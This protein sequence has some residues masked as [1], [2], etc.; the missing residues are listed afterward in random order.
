MEGTIV[1]QSYYKNILGIAFHTFKTLKIAYIIETII[2]LIGL[3]SNNFFSR[4]TMG[5]DLVPTVAT[6]LTANFIAH[7]IVFSL[8][9]SKDHG[10]LLFLTPIKGIEFLAGHF[11]ELLLVDSFIVVA[12]AVVGSIN[13]H[14]LAS[15]LITA[16]L[17]ILVGLLSAH[18]IITGTIAIVGSYIRSTGLCILGVI[19]CCGFGES[20][21]SWI[22]NA[23]ISFMP[24]FYLSIGRLGLI[25]IDIFSVILD[26]L[27]LIGLQIAAAYMI[28]KK[29]DII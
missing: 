18:L 5:L 15:M 29:L 10:K 6:L 16:S 7:I 3:F 13:A 14:G 22:N 1:K 9:I 23:V 12:A 27:A 25:E 21:Y 17:G 11:L 26:I 4:Y 28:D 2:L 20:I 24:Y 8:Q 19:L